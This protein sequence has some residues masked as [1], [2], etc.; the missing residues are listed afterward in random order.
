MVDT[1][2]H[3][4]Q[5]LFDPTWDRIVRE[6]H[7]RFVITNWVEYH[8]IKVGRYAK[9]QEHCRLVDDELYDAWTAQAQRC[10]YRNRSHLILEF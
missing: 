6:F 9:Q 4:Q 5:E 2:E 7:G 10:V 8:P 1:I 3:I